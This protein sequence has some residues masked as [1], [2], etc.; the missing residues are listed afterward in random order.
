MTAALW[1]CPEC[2]HRSPV[3]PNAGVHTHVDEVGNE[4]DVE[5]VLLEG[6]A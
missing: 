5:A 4:Y 1:F 2:E 3:M 6:N